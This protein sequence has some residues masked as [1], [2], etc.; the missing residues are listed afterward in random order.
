MKT[1]KTLC[2]TRGNLSTG[3]LIFVCASIMLWHVSTDVEG[4]IWSGTRHIDRH[5]D[6]R[7]KEEEIKPSKQSS[8]A[9]FLRRVHLDLI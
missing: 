3:L 1:M 6:A 4:R 2:Q 9:E 7:L 8:D 5:I